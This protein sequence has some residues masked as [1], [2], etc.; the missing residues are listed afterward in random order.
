[1]QFFHLVSFVVVASYAAALPQPVGL[2][3]K[4]SNNGSATLVSL[5]RRDDSEDDSEFD[6]SD[7]DFDDDFDDDDED[8]DFDDDLATIMKTIMTKIMTKIVNLK[9][10]N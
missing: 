10:L 9:I 8:D 6:D 3:E 5:K 1:M 7:D 4:Y 2:S